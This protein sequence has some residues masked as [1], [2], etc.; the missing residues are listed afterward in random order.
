[1]YL[2]SNYPKKKFTSHS[3]VEI[4]NMKFFAPAAGY[5]HHHIHTHNSTNGKRRREKDLSHFLHET[6]HTWKNFACR[7][8]IEPCDWM[9]QQIWYTFSIPFQ[10]C[11][12]RSHAKGSSTPNTFCRFWFFFFIRVMSERHPFFSALLILVFFSSPQTFLFYDDFEIFFCHHFK[13]LQ[14]RDVINIWWIEL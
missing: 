5:L 10:T 8:T 12:S 4:L 7:Y 2:L 14:M 6:A 3:C 9:K 11:L 1:M 13:Y